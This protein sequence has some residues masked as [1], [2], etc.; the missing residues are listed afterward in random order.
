[1]KEKRILSIALSLL[2]AFSFVFPM[3][4]FAEEYL[5]FEDDYS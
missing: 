4:A 5:F 2:L 1:M 3:G